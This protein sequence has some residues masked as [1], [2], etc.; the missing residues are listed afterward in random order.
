MASKNIIVDLN[1]GE[2]LDS[3]NYDIWHR[4]VQYLLDEQEVL[5]TL[6]QSMDTPLEEGS[7]SQ[8]RH[9]NETYAK[10]A[11]KDHC[12]HFI[13]LSSMHNDLV[14]TFE[15]YK[16]AHEMCN[17]LKLKFDETSA[18]RLHA[19]TLKLTLIRAP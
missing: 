14:S 4:K 10:W 9:D 6:R 8:H 2:K 19:L 1:K 15:D 18:T 17:A 3:D 5:K 12:A 13:M 7:G 11:K 16:T